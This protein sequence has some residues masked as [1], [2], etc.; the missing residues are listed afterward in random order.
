MKYRFCLLNF[1]QHSGGPR[2]N[3]DAAGR[4]IE[5]CLF[6]HIIIG[7][8]LHRVQFQR[9]ADQVVMAEGHGLRRHI[10]RRQ[11]HLPRR[12]KVSADR[13]RKQHHNH[14][15]Q[16]RFAVFRVEEAHALLN[17]LGDVQP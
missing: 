12:I 15:G 6:D 9:C 4:C 1:L 11:H 7:I 13:I 16:L 14:A 17:L 2:R 3:G 5:Y 10:D 8:L